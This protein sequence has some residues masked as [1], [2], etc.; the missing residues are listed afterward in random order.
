MTETEKRMHRVCFTGHRPEKLTRHEKSITKDLENEIR[1][2][3]ADTIA[4]C[5]SAGCNGRCS[6]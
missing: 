2:A 4:A 3:V 5:Q 6:L 1:Q